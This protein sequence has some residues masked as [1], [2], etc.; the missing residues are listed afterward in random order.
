MSQPD[1]RRVIERL[2]KVELKEA[3]EKGEKIVPFKLNRS[4]IELDS[5]VKLHRKHVIL[6]ARQIGIST[7]VIARFLAKCL[8][9]QGTHAV[10]I[11]HER[12][13]TIKLLRK[14]KFFID[15]LRKQ[16]IVVNTD[17]DSKAEMTFPD[18]NSSLYIGTAG[19]KAFSRG[20]T[21]TDVLASEGAFWED[22]ADLMR[23]VMGA[24]VPNGEVFLESTAQGAGGYFYDM[25][26][27]SMAAHPH[28]KKYASR[29]GGTSDWLFHF[30]PWTDDP[31]YK[32]EPPKLAPFWAKE[33]QALHDAGLAWNRIWWRRKKLEDYQTV[34]EFMAEFPLTPDEAFMVTGSCYFDKGTLRLYKSLVKEPIAT[35]QV[36]MVGQ[37][38]R[39]NRF[40]E[41][42]P[43]LIWD[44]PKSGME[45]L[46]SADC[47]EGVDDE[48][49]DPSVA[50]VL[51][52]TT[53]KQA[54]VLSGKIDP[55]EYAQHLYALGAYYGWAWVAIE[56]NG[57]G[58]AVLLKLRELG[59]PR[60]YHHKR[61]DAE[62]GRE[63]EK[64]GWHTDQRTRTPMLSELR[65]MVRRQTLH[66]VDERFLK[67][68]T[69]FCRQKDG[70][71]R[72]NSGCHDDHV[73]SMGI[74]AYLHNHMPMDLP[75]DDTRGGLS[76]YYPA[77]QINR[78]IGRTGY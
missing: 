37:Q 72:A 28:W 46:V 1:I 32:L 57:P 15:E 12:Q 51:N 68:C 71:Y 42:A 7:Y 64:I 67:E 58:L 52:R 35:G 16:G 75:Q 27:K 63:V 19:Q 76:S 18:S 6:K 24:L 77:Q 36:E 73:M 9:R 3:N 23:G 60:I 59:Y 10:I 50:Q 13:A 11:S 30:Y 29:D 45:Y 20:D 70:T 38:S 69:T 26:Q 47:S 44:Y 48:D 21:I 40:T 53:L 56:D 39:F 49:T 62:A 74:A 2:F 61:I 31:G 5:S 8:T 43:L 4:Q 25:A 33:E 17:Y 78:G 14:A 54:A 55:L 66:I 65:Q 41:K 22:A 34:E